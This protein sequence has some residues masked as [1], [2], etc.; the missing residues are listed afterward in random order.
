MTNHSQKPKRAKRR[1]LAPMLKSKAHMAIQ[2]FGVV[3][4]T[5]DKC[6]RIHD[7]FVMLD[8]KYRWVKKTQKEY[9]DDV[10]RSKLKGETGMFVSREK[11][12]RVPHQHVWNEKLV[13]KKRKAMKNYLTMNEWQFS[14]EGAVCDRCLKEILDRMLSDDD[15]SPK[16]DS[17]L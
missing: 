16:D 7:E 13:R 2:E 5:C 8:T 12:V 11:C 14:D 17:G 1:T 4:V 10:A 15:Y 6:N 9:E 3:R